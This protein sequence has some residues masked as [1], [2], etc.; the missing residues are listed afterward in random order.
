MLRRHYANPP[1]T[2][3]V[4]DIRAELGPDVRLENLA[5]FQEHIKATYPTRQDLMMVRANIEFQPT[6]KV[7]SEQTTLGYAFR[8][9]D[10][11]QIVQAR[12]NGFSFSRL[13]PYENWNSL[14]N[15]ARIMWDVYKRVAKP[16]RAIRV[17]VRYINR[18]DMPFPAVELRD[19]LR[20]FPEISPELP[21]SM[22]RYVMQLLIPIEDFGGTL[23]LIEASVPAPGPDISSI[24]L[25]IDLFKESTAEF[26]SDEKVWGLLEHFR[27]KK[28]EIFEKCITDKARKLFVP[29]KE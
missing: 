6:G 25:D 23:S 17:A 7:K 28:N 22:A 5:A 21:Q 12:T 18:I 29:V 27:D 3:A 13:H 26:D 20:T 9:A 2:E 1:I 15:E 4:I 24:N 19:Y 16:I 11:K 14:R 8:S 10:G